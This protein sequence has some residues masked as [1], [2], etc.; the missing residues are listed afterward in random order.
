MNKLKPN[1]SLWSFIIEKQPS[2]PHYHLFASHTW[3]QLKSSYTAIHW[4][5][6]TKRKRMMQSM[7]FYPSVF[8]LK[9]SWKPTSVFFTLTGNNSEV[10]RLIFAFSQNTR[11]DEGIL[12]IFQLY[13]QKKK[14]GK[15]YFISLVCRK[16]TIMY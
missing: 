16:T 4:E 6:F 15:R 12:S 14:K 8:I 1:K 9:L 3:W 2:R 13:W 5:C 11:I 7:Q 10:N